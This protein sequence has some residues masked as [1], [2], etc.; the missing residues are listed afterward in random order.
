MSTAT[1]HKRQLFHWIGK[2]IDAD[3]SLDSAGRIAAYVGAL[4][5]SLTGGLWMNRMDEELALR[6]RAHRLN[7]RM[8][9]LTENRLSECSYHA[10]RYGRLG[11]GF[12]KRFVLDAG[13]KPVSYVAN[14]QGD[15][16]TRFLLEA[17]EAANAQGLSIG[18][19]LD[20]VAH[21]VKP[22]GARKPPSTRR[23]A[24]S[25][26]GPAAKPDALVQRRQYGRAMIF[27]SE[28]EWRVV[29]DASLLRRA[30]P[31]IRHE[32]ARSYL[33]YAAGPDLMT[34]VFPDR[35]TQQA[36]MADPEIAATLTGAPL[37]V[38]V[39]HLDEINEL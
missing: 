5:G 35:A 17:L 29:E 3:R 15:L 25:G 9:C 38:N 27:Q 32:H 22:L 2:H 10:R 4:R 36:A 19:Q 12:P 11:L 18:P 33:N 14:K 26:A 31:M 21:F 16:H 34:I 8:V 1:I 7:R 37:P 24:A 23:R 6:R 30:H 13:G 28:G 39:F 20:F